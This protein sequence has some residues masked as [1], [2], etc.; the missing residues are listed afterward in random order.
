MSERL[1]RV[2]VSV[3]KSGFFLKIS[4]ALLISLFVFRLPAWSQEDI[5]FEQFSPQGE[6]HWKE[7][8]RRQ[9]RN[10]QA[11]YQLGRYY[12]FTK[13]MPDAAEMYRQATLIDQGSALAH[14]GLGKAYREL[15]RYQEA[16]TALHRAVALKPNFSRAYHFL[17]LVY[18]GLGRYPEAAEA[19]VNAYTYNPGWAETYYDSTTYGIHQ[20]L[21]S[22][23]EV[24]LRLVKHV[25]PINQHLA[26]ILYNR[27]ARGNAG[28]KEF[29]EV[30]AGRELPADAGYHRGPVVGY[31]APQE[32]GTQ[33]PQDVGYR[34]RPNQ[35]SAPEGFAE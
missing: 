5:R 3:P 21:G 8:L 25:Y 7:V 29:W 9:P 11:Y 32:V 14:F 23:K 2:A 4:M 6:R 10:P 26:R 31:V 18:V 34:R 19:L 24:V 12:E 13:R 20:E 30:V 17:G 16:A 15:N 35:P 28:M 27:W 1:S 22:D 33:G